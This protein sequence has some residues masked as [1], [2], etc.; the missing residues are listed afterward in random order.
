M[1]E[2]TVDLTAMMLCNEVRGVGSLPFPLAKP[3][4]CFDDVTCLHPFGGAD[5]RFPTLHTTS[6]EIHNIRSSR[7]KTLDA[8][9]RCTQQLPRL[10]MLRLGD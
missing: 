1:P 3:P 9:A 10:D 7:A 4:A 2:G 8:F 6:H 5:L